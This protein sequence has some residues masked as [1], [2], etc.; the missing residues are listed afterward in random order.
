MKAE[1]RGHASKAQPRFGHPAR[2]R[3]AS[4]DGAQRF[5]LGHPRREPPPIE[6][7]EAR[8]T[9]GREADQ[10]QLAFVDQETPRNLSCRLKLWAC[11]GWCALALSSSG[12][13][14]D[15]ATRPAEPRDPELRLLSSLRWTKAHAIPTDPSNRYAD[16]PRA[17]DFG[18]ILFFERRLSASGKISCATCHA[19]DRAFTDGRARARGAGP[20][21]R[22][23]PTLLGA[24]FARWLYW[25]G[26]R[27]SL[28]SQALVPIEA[29]NEMDGNRMAVVRLVAQDSGLRKT[30]ETIF[31]PLPGIS[32][33]RRL[34][35]G[36][37]PFGGA[38]SRDAWFRLPKAQRL[39]VN[40]I[41]ANLGKALAAFERTL[42]PEPS[43][44]D[45]YIKARLAGDDPSGAG[46]LSRQEARGLRLFTS[47]RA[48]CLRCHNGPLL[49]NGGFH[50]LE[51]GQLTGRGLD[52][53]RSLG[54]RAVRMDEFN[55]LGPYSDADPDDCRSLRFMAEESA[56]TLGAFKVP[57]LRA[58]SQTAPYFHDGRFETLEAVVRFYSRAR[59]QDGQPVRP[60]R[61]SEAEIGDLVAF[62]KT[63]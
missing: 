51:T 15:S 1:L 7:V 26:R 38:K 62:L 31:G 55:C 33:F 50:N 44:F 56:E 32:W 39:R 13:T 61:F 28:W 34:P 17:A 10:S 29:S 9:R 11:I 5:H 53:G 16:D 14:S 52:F 6:V 8:G 63:L 46:L 2:G 58:V 42:L 47:E 60:I 25:D 12:C 23:T 45:H 21:S 22:N 43:R 37:G 59:R 27:D 40:R 3:T 18:K 54:M 4:R 30:Y 41:Y 24:A 19:P 49:S 20:G 36:A 57:T 35:I 48:R